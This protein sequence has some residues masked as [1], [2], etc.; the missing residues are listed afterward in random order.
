[1]HRKNAT[2]YEQE[3]FRSAQIVW[4]LVSCLPEACC[5]QEDE[6]IAQPGSAPLGPN[7]NLFDPHEEV[8]AMWPQQSDG[9][10]TVE[11]APRSIVSTRRFSL[12]MSTGTY[13]SPRSVSTCSTANPRAEWKPACLLHPPAHPS[14]REEKEDDD[15]VQVW[16]DGS[17]YSGQL[18]DDL[19]HG[20]GIL[21]LADGS[22][23]EGEWMNSK[24]HGEGMYT[25]MDGCSYRGQW[26][27]EV[28]HGHGIEHYS[29]GREYE[30]QFQNGMKHGD[31]MFVFS[32]G[33]RIEGQFA[34][35]SIGGDGIYCWSDGRT[36]Q[37]QWLDNKMHGK[38]AYSFPDGGR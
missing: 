20:R 10:E 30:G 21:K 23:Y 29:D 15:S 34:W 4:Q 11:N 28:K 22:S 3:I 26:S 35:D 27:C 2:V 33:A 31:G 37:G 38:G 36:Y 9:V 25:R 19:P 8:P 6:A 24:A 5:C 18:V 16:P 7:R 1:M 14:S 17:I 32:D 12:S 13:V